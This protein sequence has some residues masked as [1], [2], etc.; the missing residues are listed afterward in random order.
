MISIYLV[1]NLLNGH[2]YVGKTKK[3]I[4]KRLEEHVG[5]SRHTDT[6]FARA[7]RKYGAENF[8]ISLLE[9]TSEEMW[10]ERETFH[11]AKLHPEYNMTDGG[12]GAHGR[13]MTE[14][15][16]EKLRNFLIGKSLPETVKLKN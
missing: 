6:H 15:A 16:K 11:I 2:R 4:E 10:R 13:V 5:K 9:T 3:V 14:E 12:E 7:I 8:T 1:T